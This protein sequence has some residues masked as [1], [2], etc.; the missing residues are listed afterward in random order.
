M[1]NQ[2]LYADK[3]YLSLQLDNYSP[4]MY[5]HT[6][7]DTL[8]ILFYYHD[9]EAYIIYRCVVYWLYYAGFYKQVLNLFM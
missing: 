9:Y 1:K 6:P 2:L 7:N 4:D 3:T 8:N 5:F